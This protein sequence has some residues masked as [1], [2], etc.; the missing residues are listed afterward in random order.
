MSQ[1]L[2]NSL[3][4]LCTL[5]LSSTVLAAS[6]AEIDANVAATLTE[7][8]ATS[9][10]GQKL[11]QQAAGM[12]VF[13]RVIKAGIGIGGEYG[14]GALIVGGSTVWQAPDFLDT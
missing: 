12:L 9:N 10:A 7:F 8:Y 3:I 2:R 11:A 4:A 5:F 13:P 6:K 1:T 14:E